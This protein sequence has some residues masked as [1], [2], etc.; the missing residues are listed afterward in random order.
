M[1]KQVI[2]TARAKGDLQKIYDFNSLVIGEDKAFELIER[3]IEKAAILYKPIS[4]GSRYISN[5]A[6]EINYQKL[7][8]G[9]HLI[10]YRE[11]S[12][13]SYINRIFDARQDP[14]KIK[15]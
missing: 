8:F 4:G 2:W 3:L 7:I 9:N 15:L 5:L 14:S 6:P 1:E 10:I 13:I 12:N 11:E